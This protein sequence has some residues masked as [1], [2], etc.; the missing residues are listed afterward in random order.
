MRIKPDCIQLLYFT[1]LDTIDNSHRP[2]LACDGTTSMCSISQHNA[3]VKL[4]EDEGNTLGM[5]F[6]EL[7]WKSTLQLQ[8]LGAV[9]WLS[10][11][12]SIMITSNPAI[13]N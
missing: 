11:E 7:E 13:S 9:S 6:V 8:Y 4:N 2:T 1:W 5:H 12:L 10:A 3:M